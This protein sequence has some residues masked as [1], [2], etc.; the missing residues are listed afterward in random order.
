M[1]KQDET[2]TPE[3]IKNWRRIAKNDCKKP[4]GKGWK[5]VN[6]RYVKAC[7]HSNSI[8]GSKGRYC[9]DCERYV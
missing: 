9:I 2:L 3:Q 4:L 7:D 5:R 6:G 1:E 8:V